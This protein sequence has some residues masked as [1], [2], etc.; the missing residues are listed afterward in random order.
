MSVLLL[1]LAG[2]MQSWGHASRFSRRDTATMPTKSGVLGLLA[3]AQGRRRTDPIEDLAH[4]RFGVRSDQPGQLMR[5]FQVA[6]QRNQT[7]DDVSMPLSQRYYLADAV[8]LAGVEGDPSLI[9][10]LAEAV[11]APR[12]SLY[13][14]R[15][16]CPTTGQLFLGVT[17]QPLED[18]LREHEW[19]AA[20]WY[21]HRQQRHL[22]LE[23]TTDST[24][25]DALER[26]RPQRDVPVSFD[27]LH[28]EYGWRDVVEREPVAITNEDGL[29]PRASGIDWLSEVEQS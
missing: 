5:D 9:E 16:S 26:T 6:I 11:Q 10:G 2:P 7:K 25:E 15:R 17:D 29:P 12:F 1:R 23:L 19:L 28:R 22:D 14:G 24:P 8:F 3:A 27:P 4:L 18:A 21:R 20:R 13:L